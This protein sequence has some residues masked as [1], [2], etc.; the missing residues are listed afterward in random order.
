[1]SELDGLLLGIGL[2]FRCSAGR[3]VDNVSG[4]LVNKDIK[5]C[6]L[7]LFSSSGDWGHVC[8]V[9]GD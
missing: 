8:G 6:A 3:L 2:D 9:G 1:M 7:A 4:C 5:I